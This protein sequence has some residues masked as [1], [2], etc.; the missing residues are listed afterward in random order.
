MPQN[1]KLRKKN[2]QVTQLSTIISLLE[3][4]WMVKNEKENNWETLN[5]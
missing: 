1:F 5:Y 4:R 3:Y 2:I